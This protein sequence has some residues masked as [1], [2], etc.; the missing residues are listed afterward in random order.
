MF[1][2]L[3]SLFRQCL[4]MKGH[5]V[6]SAMTISLM[7]VHARLH[8]RV[9]MHNQRVWRLASIFCSCHLFWMDESVMVWK[10]FPNFHRERHDGL[11]WIITYLSCKALEEFMFAAVNTLVFSSIIFFLVAFQG[12][13]LFYW[14]L[15]W[16]LSC[17]SVGARPHS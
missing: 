15:Q 5:A 12:S 10:D 11:Y 14:L 7:P 13:F 4:H 6:G 2:V 9:P 16:C 3:P 17:L 1:L 8:E